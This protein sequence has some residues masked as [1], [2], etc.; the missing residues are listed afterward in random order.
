MMF[1]NILNPN[2]KL[3]IICK[4]LD[5]LS[6]I[7]NFIMHKSIYRFNKAIYTLHAYTMY[8]YSKI[9]IF[10]V[11]LRTYSNTCIGLVYLNTDCSI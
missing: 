9:L 5:Y 8:I 3:L 2:L 1:L 10:T 11:S 7:H 4:L 6:K